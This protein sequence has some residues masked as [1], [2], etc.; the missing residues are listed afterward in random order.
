MTLQIQHSAPTRR[1]LGEVPE[2]RF[3]MD[4]QPRKAAP[5]EICL[6]WISQGSLELL[7]PFANHAP[8]LGGLLIWKA[9]SWQSGMD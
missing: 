9:N 5:F 1:R 4:L 6:L 8:L 3:P 7:L 2:R